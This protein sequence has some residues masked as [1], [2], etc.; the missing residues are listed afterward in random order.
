MDM[1]T[2]V[3]WI[4]AIIW[5]LTLILWVGRLLRGET[6]MHP[7]IKG[8]FSSNGLLGT[9]VFFG[10]V[11]SGISLYF[12][13][14]C[15]ARPKELTLNISAYDPPYPAPMRVIS[16]QKFENQDVPLDGY[17]YENCS[18]TNVCFMY[19]G[20]AYGLHNS[21]V[22]EHWKVCVADS[23]LKNYLALMDATYALIE[24]GKTTNRTIVKPR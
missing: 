23:R 13:Y 16:D 15:H 19:D 12:S 5:A 18:F 11:M 9:I 14:T 21:T 7:W 6:T 20:G 3:S 2:I 4:Q 24:P 8:I 10:L 17:V 22:K 1:G